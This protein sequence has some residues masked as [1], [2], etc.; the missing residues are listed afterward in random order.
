MAENEKK[1]VE[2]LKAARLLEI[3]VFSS[4]PLMQGALN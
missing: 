4:S 2:L 3:N 1:K